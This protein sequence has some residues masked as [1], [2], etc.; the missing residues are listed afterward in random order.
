MATTKKAEVDEPKMPEFDGHLTC[1]FEAGNGFSCAFEFDL[2]NV[3]GQMGMARM[4]E[5]SF[6][7]MIN[8]A[9]VEALGANGVVKK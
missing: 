9:L 6:S 2:P 4:N 7:A 1:V 8:K 5:A 3:I